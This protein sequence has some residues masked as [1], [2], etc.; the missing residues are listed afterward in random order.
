ML[1]R[2]SNIT[3]LVLC[4]LLVVGITITRRVDTAIETN[5]NR[6]DAARAAVLDFETDCIAEP[7]YL[8]GKDTASWVRIEYTLPSF[9]SYNLDKKAGQ[10]YI[11][12][13]PTDTAATRLYLGKISTAKTYCKVL[14]T[15][16]STLKLADYQLQ[17]VT[18]NGDTMRYLTYVVDT[19]FI[20]QD[21]E[22]QLYS[23]NSDSLFWKLYFGKQRFIPELAEQ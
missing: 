15:N 7:I 8:V 6:K 18:A 1:K 17:I 4:G 13:M 22:G 12:G 11:D 5:E 21:M 14:H 10:W 9:S 19:N 2:L 16:P 23:G 3:L 20:V